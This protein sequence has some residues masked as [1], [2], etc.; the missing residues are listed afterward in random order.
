L[1]RPRK[2]DEPLLL[3]RENSTVPRFTD[4]SAYR[5]F[6]SIW[7]SIC[8][9]HGLKKSFD[10]CS[11]IVWTNNLGKQ[12]IISEC[13]KQYFHLRG[14]YL[15]AKTSAGDSPVIGKA[16]QSTRNE[17]F[18][19]VYE[20]ALIFQYQPPLQNEQFLP[21]EFQNASKVP[22]SVVTGYHDTDQSPFVV[23]HPHPCHK[24][25]EALLPLIHTWTR[26]NDLVLDLFSG[27][28]AIAHAVLTAGEGR[29]VRGMEIQQY[30]AKYSNDK[31][32]TFFQP[33]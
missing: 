23:P 19:R 6:T 13:N 5:S 18:L 25:L 21:I 26:P 10:R 9:Q 15:W 16:M 27:S 11:L 1:R 31:I 24:P 32:Q 20:S 17:T 14:E 28:G 8:L 33:S 29:N 7:L 3:D 2:I 12:V 22:W 4:V 30:W